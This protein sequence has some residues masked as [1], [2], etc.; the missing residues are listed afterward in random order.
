MIADLIALPE[1]CGTG[2]GAKLLEHLQE[3]AGLRG[4]AQLHLDTGHTRHAAHKSYLRNGF[5]II[6]RHMAW[7]PQR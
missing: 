5:D 7:N 3:Q 6:C 4:C 1:R 2:L